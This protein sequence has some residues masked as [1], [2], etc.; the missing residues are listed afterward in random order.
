VNGDVHQPPGELRGGALMPA[1]SVNVATLERTPSESTAGDLVV[2]EP[3]IEDAERM[4]RLVRDSGTLDLN[5]GYAYLLLCRH[6]RNTCLL[7][8]DDDGAIAGF[9]VG[10]RPPDAEDTMFVWQ[11]GVSTR[12][13]RRGVGRTLLLAL[14]DRLERVRFLEATVTP[15]NEPSRRLFRSVAR[16]LDARFETRP[17]FDEDVLPESDHEPETLVR[18]GPL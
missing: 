9:V 14:L 13:R 3:R 11:I 1:G 8:E 6:F 7:A 4:W 15:S 10:Y 12:H 18:I 16:S 5:S 2:R 17:Y